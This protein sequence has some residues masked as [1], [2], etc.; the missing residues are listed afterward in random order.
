MSPA[1]TLSG[2]ATLN[3]RS[4]RFGRD[5]KVVLAVGRDLEPALA[6]GPDAMQLHELLHTVLAHTNAACEQLFPDA[7][8]AVAAACFG[9][10]G[11]DV[12]QQRVVA[13]MAALGIAGSANEV[14]VV[15]RN[16]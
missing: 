1:Q 16:A 4:S 10:D 2:S 9:V 6:L 5:R 11:L 13:Q 8:P 15:P 7:W 14:L 3:C 12:H